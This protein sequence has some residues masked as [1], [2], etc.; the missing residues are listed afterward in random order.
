MAKKGKPKKRDWYHITE[1]IIDRAI[2]PSLVVL[3]CIII[4]ELF[5]HDIADSYHTLI[6]SL[7]YVVVGIFM[8]D[9]IFKYQRS[10]KFG[11]FLKE[12]WLDIVAVFPFFLLFRLLGPL[13][14]IGDLS[15]EAKEIQ[16]IFHES[17]ELSKSGSKIVKEAEIAGKLSRT[18]MLAA[19]FRAAGRVPRFVK[20]MPFFE[21]PTKR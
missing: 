4:I 6:I 10:K 3:L 15:K 2:P 9:L 1:H 12:S 17:L 8:V 5:F 7:D 20:A 14:F 19:A 18:R 16:L 11:T 21:K 13:L